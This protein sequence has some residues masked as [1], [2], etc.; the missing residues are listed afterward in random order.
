VNERQGGVWNVQLTRL[1]DM[2]YDPVWS[3]AGDKIA[4]VSPAVDSDDIWIINVDG[5]EAQPL[6]PNPWE[7]EKHPTWSPDGE[8][9]VFWSNRSGLMQ[10]YIMNA[11]GTE[12]TNISNTE[13]DEYDPVWIKE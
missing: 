5:S 13:W 9:I 4:F 7:W 10:I 6:T 1:E 3:P 12:V 11:D 8:Q 2:C